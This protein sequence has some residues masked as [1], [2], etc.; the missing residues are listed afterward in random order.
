MTRT[1]ILMRHAKSSWDTPMLDDHDRP[2]NKRGRKSAQALGDWMALE[3]FLPDQVLC[4]TAVRTQ[5]TFRGL[6]IALEPELRPDLYHADPSDMLAV[7]KEANGRT[8]L[9]IGHNPGIAAFAQ[10]LVAEDPDHDRFEDYPTGATLVVR[11]DIEDWGK[12]VPGTGAVV[13][14]VAPR[15]LTDI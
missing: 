12:L 7:L 6:D 13:D 5:E 1:L 10:A 3:G 8:V 14:F 4:S 9:M 15:E 2:L 11:F